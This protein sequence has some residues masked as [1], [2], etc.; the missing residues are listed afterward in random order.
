MPP[1]IPVQ[2]PAWL[3]NW[4][5]KLV[6]SLL[7]GVILPAI[8]RAVP[9]FQQ[10]ISDVIAFLKTGVVS[11]ELKASVQHYHTL[12]AARGRK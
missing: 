6:V 1:W 11:D 2:L 10:F 7:T 5:V 9:K 12:Q 3:P 4:L 8:G